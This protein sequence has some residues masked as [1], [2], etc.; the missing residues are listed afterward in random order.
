MKK[1]GRTMRKKT[2]R[3][4]L[5]GLFLALG[6]V[7]PLL[8]GQIKEIGDSLLPMHLAVMLCGLICGYKYGLVVGL[9]LPFLRSLIFGMPPLY[10]NAIWMALELATYGLVIGL[11]YVKFKKKSTRYVYLSLIISMI[12]GRVVWGLAKAGL[13]GL[14]GKG[15]TLYALFVSGFVDAIPGI[16]LQL[17]LIPTIMHLINR[18]QEDKKNEDS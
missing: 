9:T 7:L 5:S 1:R 6:M 14:M 8:T 4:V 13:L 15:V 11:L 2:K 12:A 10:P 17:L 18:K 3:L 16:I